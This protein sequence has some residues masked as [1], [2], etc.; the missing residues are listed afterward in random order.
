M[1]KDKVVVITGAGGIICSEMANHLASKGAKVALLDLNKQAAQ[2]F[3]NE[4]T[5]KGG[6]A[7]AYE[8]NVLKMDSIKAAHEEVLKDFGFC[9]ILINGAGGNNPKATTENEYH[10]LNLP[11]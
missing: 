9:D 1:L 8:C 5:K 2:E 4:I 7:K 6:V 3:A 10:E 11:N